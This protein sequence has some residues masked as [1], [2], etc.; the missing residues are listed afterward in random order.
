MRSKT[1]SA[2]VP[3]RKITMLLFAAHFFVIIISAAHI[4]L[5][6]NRQP[7]SRAAWLVLVFALPFI[8]ALMYFFLGRTNIGH[9]RSQKLR[10]AFSAL[11]RPDTPQAVS[12]AKTQP[13]ADRYAALFKVGESISGYQAVSGNSA[14]L[15]A[16]SD[17]TISQMI[18]DIDAAQDHVHLLFYIWLADN[19]GT[20]M[21]EALMRAARRGVVCRALVDNL[22]SREFIQSNLWKELSNA[23]VKTLTALGDGSPWRSL[24][25]SRIDLRNHRKILVI[26]NQITYC[27]SQNC[28]DP[29]F[30]PKAKY[31][32]WVDAV[33]RFE[34][35]VVRQNQHLFASDWM[36]N[37]GDDI[38]DILLQPAK[39]ISSGF[40]AQVIGTGPTFR[41]SAMPELFQ[42]LIYA[43][44]EELCITTPYYVPDAALQSALRASANRGVITTLILPARNDDFAVGATSR[45]YYEDLLL[46]G[47]H[48]YEFQPGLLHTKSITVDNEVALIGSANMDRRSFDLNYENN[49]LLRD[50]AATAQLRERQRSY[51]DQSRKVTLDD[52]RTWGNFERLKNNA[53]AILS[54]VL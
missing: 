19:N 1:S 39:Q 9:E 30:L 28:A 25:K 42:T 35:P 3:H 54:P 33:M 14:Q 22:G 11:P 41:S 13:C 40:T 45:S 2:L 46:A 24:F 47:V 36:G 31:A 38:T 20:K 52:V 43:A 32:P 50:K 18:A 23:G 8:G 27:G 4:L 44:Q 37:G 16:D 29:A 53:L 49:I 7:E 34:G 6:S 21:A 15:M 5:R 12:L 10:Q 17:A 51:C 48:I 26:D